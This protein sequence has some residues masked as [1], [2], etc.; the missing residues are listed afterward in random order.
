[1]TQPKTDKPH[2]PQ[3]TKNDQFELVQYDETLRRLGGSEELFQEFVEIFMSDSPEMI[4]TIARAVDDDNSAALEQTA[5]SLH[6]LMLN[7]GANPCCEL[8][9]A[10]ELSL[11]HI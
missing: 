4:N 5:H 7:F 3:E 11:I 10:F 2:A 8:T 6:G 1:M 9:Q